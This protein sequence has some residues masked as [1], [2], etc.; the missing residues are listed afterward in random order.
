MLTSVGASQIGHIHYEKCSQILL[1]YIAMNSWIH[2][3]ILEGRGGGGGGL[4]SRGITDTSCQSKSATKLC[5][6]V[7]Q[8][9]IVEFILDLGTKLAGLKS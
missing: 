2:A 3:R 6:I 8:P 4:N 9:D 7:Q 1:E 5:T